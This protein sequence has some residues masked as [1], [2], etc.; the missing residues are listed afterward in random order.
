MPEEI[1]AETEEPTEVAEEP[2]TSRKSWR[3]F[4]NVKE[5]SE[6]DKLERLSVYA[7]V[8]EYK[9]SHLV[10]MAKVTDKDYQR[11]FFG[12]PAYMWE[13]AIPVLQKYVKNIAKIEK[14]AMAD[15]VLVELKRLK[16]LGI[17]V[18]GL[19]EKV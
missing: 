6:I 12:M 15:A 19:I 18:A 16:E 7:G 17:D 9:G 8:N 4:K 11:A 5:A 3:E 10:F 14:K 1:E 13:K 2:A